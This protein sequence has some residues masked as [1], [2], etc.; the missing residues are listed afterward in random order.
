[1]NTACDIMIMNK[2]NKAAD[3]RIRSNYINRLK[4]S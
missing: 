1:M 3:F 4:G 2:K